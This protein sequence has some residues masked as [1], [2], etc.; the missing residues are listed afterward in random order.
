[1]SFSSSRT[2]SCYPLILCMYL[3]AW[4]RLKHSEIWEVM[5]KE[6][7]INKQINKQETDCP[8]LSQPG[9]ED[10]AAELE[11]LGVVWDGERKWVSCSQTVRWGGWSYQRPLSRTIATALQ[12]SKEKKE[13]RQCIVSVCFIFFLGLGGAFQQKPMGSA[14]IGDS[15]S[16]VLSPECRKH[17]RK[18][19]TKKSTLGDKSCR[20][21]YSA[22]I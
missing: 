17:P 1:M 10:L 20:W 7:N 16:R 5:K 18:K 15:S 4:Q 9:P 14:G 2:I 8:W 6:K 22:V 19:E 12:K 3:S 11:V 13:G 21:S